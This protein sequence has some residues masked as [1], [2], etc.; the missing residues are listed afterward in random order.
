VDREQEGHHEG[1][2]ENV[3]EKAPAKNLPR[4]ALLRLDGAVRFDLAGRLLYGRWFEANLARRL[5]E[6]SVRRQI[7]ALPLEGA[8]Q[9]AVHLV[10]RVALVIHQSTNIS[11]EMRP[12]GIVPCASTSAWKSRRLK[13]VPFSFL[14]RS[15]MAKIASRPMR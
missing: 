10:A 8:G 2:R 15:R 4:A 1:V 14:Y 5:D 11:R 13:P 7:A 12:T 3:M 6:L 9:N